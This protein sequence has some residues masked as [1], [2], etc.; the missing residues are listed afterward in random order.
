MELI[1]FIFIYNILLIS[2]LGYGFLFSFKLTKYNNFDTNKI[3]IGYIGIFGILF[4]ITLSYFTQLFVP[5]NNFHNI[6]IIFTGILLFSYFYFKNKSNLINKYFLLAY[7]ISFFSL[8]FFKNHDDFSYYHLSFINNLTLNKVEFGIHNFDIAFNHTSSLFYFHSLFKTFFTENYFYQ[9]GQLGIIVFVNTILFERIFINKKNQSLDLSF[10]FSIFF[11][12]FVNI[13]FYRLAE[14]GTDRSA[15]IL[16]FLVFL[17]SLMVVQYKK[18]DHSLFELIIIIFTLLITMKSFY[19]LYSILF[20]Y[21][22]IK[23]FKINQF[24][25]LFNLFPIIYFCFFT[26]F[27]MLIHNIASS[28]CLIYP[29]S[30]TCSDSFFWGYGKENVLSAMQW[31]EV[32]SKAGA[33]PNYRVEDFSEYINNFNWVSNWLN[34]YFFNKMSD[35]LLGVIFSTIVVMILFKIK[36]ISFK[37]LRNYIPFKVILI[38]LIIEWF[39]NHPTLRY[40]GYVLFFLI[41][42]FPVCIILEEQS[43]KFKNK[44]KSINI[45]VS[46]ILIIFVARNIDRMVTEISVYN[47]DFI[48]KPYYNIQENFFTI[49]NKK[50]EN[51]YDPSI[52]NLKNSKKEIKCIL[53]KNY[54]FYFK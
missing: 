38:I 10:F 51:F 41:I 44:I 8:F 21:L 54:K 6:V 37:K 2:V 9:I 47:Y 16:F 12:I 45:V 46:L 22:I 33:T 32:W 48:K 11:L 25:N 36:I 14:H 34:N 23:F 17:L 7:L 13:F 3:S 50:I 52:C 18:L 5:H 35:F 39:F 24:R 28:G 49:K 27:L 31:Y 53:I 29:V 40:G 15:Q 43:Y 26:F 20:I 42:V 1:K 30:F 4:L 19:L